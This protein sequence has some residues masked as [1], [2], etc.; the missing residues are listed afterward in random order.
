MTRKINYGGLNVH[1]N[2]KYK[3]S[4]IVVSKNN[5]PSKIKEVIRKI[6]VLDNRPV[7]QKDTIKSKSFL[8]ERVYTT[9]RLVE[10][11][12]KKS[13]EKKNTLDL[14]SDRLKKLR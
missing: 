2:P 14:L 12:L 13:T 6:V 3:K 10:K 1:S 9:D 5:N 8:N 4:K 7:K 11:P